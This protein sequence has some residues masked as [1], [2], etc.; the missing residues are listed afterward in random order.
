MTEVHVVQL[1]A[2]SAVVLWGPC[3]RVCWLGRGGYNQV[4]HAWS[5]ISTYG[6]R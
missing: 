3:H 1:A 5:I 4:G 6:G 2:Q